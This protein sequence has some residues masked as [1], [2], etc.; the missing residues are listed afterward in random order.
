MEALEL[1]NRQQMEYIGGLERDL[2]ERAAEEVHRTVTKFKSALATNA[3]RNHV[4]T[5]SFNVLILF[6][7]FL[8]ESIPSLLSV[9]LDGH[10]RNHSGH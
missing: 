1:R 3:E 10:C 5:P 9:S 6:F 4:I 7:F 2:A 8:I